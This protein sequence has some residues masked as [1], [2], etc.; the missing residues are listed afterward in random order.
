MAISQHY[1]S[2]SP[3]GSEEELSTV[4]RAGLQSQMGLDADEI[5]ANV[6]NESGADEFHAGAA[7]ATAHVLAKLDVRPGDRILDLG[8][9]IGGPARQAA[10]AYPQCAS[11][12]GIDITPKF[13]S[14]GCKINQWKT[15]SKQ[16]AGRVELHEGDC[17]DLPQKLLPANSVE[18]AF[19]MHVAMNIKDKFAFAK[20]VARVL[21][22]GGR[23]VIFDQ[24]ANPSAPGQAPSSLASLFAS[25]CSPRAGSQVMDVNKALPY[26]L[27]WASKPEDSHCATPDEYQLAFSAAGLRKLDDL[28]EDRSEDMVAAF[29]AA[30]SKMMYYFVTNFTFTPPPVS[31]ALLMSDMPKK[32]GNYKTAVANKQLLVMELVYEKPK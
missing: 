16:L 4:L 17:T 15:I 8:C 1:A 20:E 25:C 2:E 18:K 12:V 13:V 22:P 5:E 3:G 28:C 27:P 11:V 26:P 30:Q 14:A 23:V 6:L 31:P 24:M 7:K 32:A 19:S 9:G 29:G 10:L 21:K